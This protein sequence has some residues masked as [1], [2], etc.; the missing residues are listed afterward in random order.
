VYACVFVCMC[1]SVGLYLPIRCVGLY[2]GYN[3]VVECID[4]YMYIQLNY[5]G[6]VCFILCYACLFWQSA[7]CCFPLW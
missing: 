1:R 3:F 4:V 7:V 5:R 6:L 2:I